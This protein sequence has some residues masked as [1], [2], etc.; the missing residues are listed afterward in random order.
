MKSFFKAVL[1][2]FLFKWFEFE[3]ERQILNNPII[4]SQLDSID[5]TREDIIEYNRFMIR[6]NRFL[7]NPNNITPM[8]RS[9]AIEAY[10]LSLIHI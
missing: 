10:V 8:M 7:I 5:K 9:F 4:K 2:S 6:K 1:G 3:A